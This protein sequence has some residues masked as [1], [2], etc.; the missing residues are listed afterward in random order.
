MQPNANPHTDLWPFQLKISIPITPA[1]GYLHTKFGFCMFVFVFEIG[2]ST[3]P[4]GRDGCKDAK[5]LTVVCWDG[6]TMSTVVWLNRGQN[7]TL[8]IFLYYIILY[9][10]IILLKHQQ[11]GVHT[12]NGEITVSLSLGRPI[13]RQTKWDDSSDDE[14][15]ESDVL[16]SLPD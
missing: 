8:F 14:D 7:A 3:G 4:T 13:E 16:Q 9:S 12:S 15:D 1:L 11:A 2:A 5:T 6:H 10:I